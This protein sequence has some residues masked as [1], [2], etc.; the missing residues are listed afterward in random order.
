MNRTRRLLV[1]GGIVGAGLFLWG[2]RRA[3]LSNPEAL[4]SL[5]EYHRIQSRLL[6]IAPKLIQEWQKKGL[7]NDDE[8]ASLLGFIYRESKYDIGAV[9][10]R[11]L[12]GGSIGLL[13]FRKPTLEH[14]GFQV[15]D[16]VLARNTVGERKRVLANT[17][18]LAEAFLTYKKAWYG[19]GRNFLTY[20]RET[21]RGDW[22]GEAREMRTSWW[23]GHGKQYKNL[24]AGQKARVELVIPIAQIFRRAMGMDSSL[25]WW[26]S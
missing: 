18:R 12:E 20:L 13:Q 21:Y 26:Q 24:D 16:L 15:S 19:G 11:H 23:Q 10:D 4:K 2:C 3:T 22:A 6:D 9:G 14:L 25:G 5:P 8:I 7:L 17:A 1:A